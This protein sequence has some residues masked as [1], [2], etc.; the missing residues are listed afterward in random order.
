MLFKV[1]RKE[2]VRRKLIGVV[3]VAAM[4]VGVSA[5]ASDSGS[6]GGDGG[7]V[8]I[9][10]PGVQ[11]VRWQIEAEVM[12]D[13][14]EAR[15]YD[16]VVQF[17]NDDAPTQVQQLE[18]MITQG[19]DALIVT[20]V[21][22]QS[23]G[24]PLADAK[25]AGIPI[26]SYTRLLIDTDAV[27]YYTTFDF[28]AYGAASGDS[29]LVALGIEDAEGNPTGE[30]GP[31][32]IEVVNGSPTDSV[33]YDMWAGFEETLQPY[34]DSGVLKI[35]SGQNTFDESATL[36]WT[37]E[38]AQSRME[39]II[40]ANYSDGTKLDAVWV[41]FDGMTRGVI[42][43]L[44]S[45]GFQPG[46]DEWPILP[47]GDGEID[48][49][50]AILAGE[51]YS[52]AWTDVVTLAKGAT[53]MVADV[54][55]GGDWPAPDTSFDNNKLEVPTKLYPVVNVTKDNVEEVLVKSGYYSAEDLGL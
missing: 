45:S 8:G 42:A 49:I 19:V 1:G 29:I 32:N 16:T 33:A 3:V 13:E 26:L 9:L 52:S 7:T 20:A 34:V 40:T 24:G 17:A 39:N 14:F 53:A 47:G 15:G 23:L 22:G 2:A 28:K 35:P 54:L 41:P 12:T 44:K 51:Q 5:C 36:N 37:G 50:K 6:E 27:D 55:D 18:D 46:T 4:A 10:M 30:E 31:F 48:S 11:S 38:G 21:D 25:A 43:A